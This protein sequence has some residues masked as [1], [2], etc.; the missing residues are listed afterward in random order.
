MKILLIIS[1]L[2]IG[3][4][5][6]AQD[7]L[8]LNLTKDSS[9]KINPDPALIKV[10]IESAFPGGSNAWANFLNTNLKYPRK[11]IRK[12][13]QGTVTVLFIVDKDGQVSNIQ[14]I[15]GPEDGGLREEAIRVIS[16]SGK[17]TPAVQN[18]RLVKSYKKQ[19]IAFKL[20]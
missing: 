7:S 11:A 20:E 18:G 4:S 5:A 3:A 10:E 14:A 19:P 1:I 17:W 15:S 13:I 2:L 6:K 12:K 16:I 8:Q 9:K